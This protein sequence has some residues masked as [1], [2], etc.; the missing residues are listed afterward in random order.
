MLRNRNFARLFTAYLITYSGSAM[1]PIAIAFGVLDLTGSTKDAAFVIAAPIVAQIA[2]ILIG[3]TLAD[4]TSRQ[5]L[6]VGGECLASVAQYA[7]AAL[8]LTGH[9][10]VPA[11]AALMLVNGI[12]MAFYSPAQT[13]FIPQ[14]VEPHELQAANSL[15]GAARSGAFM[16]GAAMAGVLVAFVGAGITIAIDAAS[17]ALSAFLVAGILPKQQAET[18]QSSL[19]DDLR[20][21]WKEFISHQWLWTI[22]IQFSIMVAS[23]EAVFGL[24][25]PA[26]ARD[27][28]GGPIDWGII[29][30]FDGLGTVLGGLIAMVL[31][32]KRPMLFAVLCCFFFAG[33]P[34]TMAFSLPLWAICIGAFMAGISGQLFAVFWYTT[35]QKEIPPEMLSRV[36]AY[37]H[38]GSI[39]LAPLGVV[40]GGYLYEEIG[41]QP[42]L[43]IAVAAV[44][45]PTAL[46][47]LVP[48]VRQL[49]S[50]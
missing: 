36:S 32:I 15:L 39:V 8:F 2:I 21:G 23:F 24:L 7:I 17:F 25:G 48:G 27:R 10:S 47:L 45:I 13:G 19:F 31:A 44:F 11:L 6:M 41:M 22:V 40:I 16:M 9:A 42:T 37:D 49:R 12:A 28:M 20:K 29:V 38:M 4:R 34:L 26:V 5:K 1:A 50:R 35:L 30:A 3:G 14:V 18:E 43:L 46:V 33:V